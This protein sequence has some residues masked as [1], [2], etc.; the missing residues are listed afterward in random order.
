MG[1]VNL[2][3]SCAI[4]HPDSP[5]SSFSK[6]KSI[7][8]GIAEL[9]PRQ[10][11]PSVGIVTL[12]TII[13]TGPTSTSRFTS[14]SWKNRTRFR[15]RDTKLDYNNNLREQSAGQEG[16]LCCGCSRRRLGN[17]LE[18]PS[19]R[20]MRNQVFY[21]LLKFQQIPTGGS[22]WAIP[23]LKHYPNLTELRTT[24]VQ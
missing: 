1:S 8:M 23:A 24:S 21:S 10:L 11:A 19:G 17:Q 16:R 9:T 5:T 20:K 4:S 22:A 7:N 12:G 6:P 18:D 2:G 15:A 14:S 13:R 3:T